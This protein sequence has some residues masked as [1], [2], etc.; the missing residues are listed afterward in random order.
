MG[1]SGDVLG[2]F[3]DAGVFLTVGRDH[4]EDYIALTPWSGCLDLSS[5]I[6]GGT[7]AISDKCKHSEVVVA[8]ADQ[9]YTEEGGKL[10]WMGVEGETYQYNDQGEWE[11]ILGKGHG[12]DITTVR[13]SVALQGGGQV[14]QLLLFLLKPG[15]P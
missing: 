13:A 1:Q 11:W 9:F 15:N 4:D 7:L 14:L 8:W 10:A 6:S 2:S 5:G 12:D 3:F